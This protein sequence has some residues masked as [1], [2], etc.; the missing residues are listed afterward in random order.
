MPA[1]CAGIAFAAIG[2]GALVPAA[3]MSI[4]AA[5]L[6]TRDIYRQFIRP[7]ASS[8]EE[9]RVSRIAS[10]AVKSGAV[11]AIVLLNP[12]FSLDLQ[13]IGGVIVLQTLPAV[14]IGLFTRWFHRWALIAGLVAGLAAGLLMLYQ[15]PR[16]GPGG[17]VVRE[18]FGGSAWPLARFGWDT[19]Q[20]IYAGLVA[21][22]I[23]LTVTVTATLVLRAARVSAGVDLTEP[24]HYFL[25]EGDPTLDRMTELVDGTEFHPAHSR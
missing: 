9:T 6:F 7:H 10:L 17:V 18:H 14:A 11:A 3:I 19:T 21:V 12:Q 16:M 2:V 24:R 1:W 5:N 8:E 25:D 15:I 23:N 20:T 4:A 22:A 13:L